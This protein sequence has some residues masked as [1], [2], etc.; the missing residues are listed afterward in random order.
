MT[1]AISERTVRRLTRERDAARAE[2]DVLKEKLAQTRK[3]SRR[4]RP[5][6]ST[7]MEE[8]LQAR[9]E[10]EATAEILRAINASRSDPRPVFDTI[11][12]CAERLFPGRRASVRVV[13]GSN[14]VV[15]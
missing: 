4:N 2:V 6:G 8:L 13:E 11:V 10:Q 1:T 3:R 15:K 9:T 7:P 12:A 14:L 5:A